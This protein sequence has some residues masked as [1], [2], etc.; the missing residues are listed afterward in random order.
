MLGI[1]RQWKISAGQD[2]QAYAD[3]QISR[4]AQAA[5]QI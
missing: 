3:D 4:S 2:Q 1:N 5:T